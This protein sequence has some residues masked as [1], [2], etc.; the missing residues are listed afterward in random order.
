MDRFK[1]G[2]GISQDCILSHCLFNF[3]KEYIMRKAGVYELQ[4]GTKIDD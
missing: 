3:Y 1:I 4:A 2:K